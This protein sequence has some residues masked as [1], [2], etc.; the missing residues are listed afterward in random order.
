MKLSVIQEEGWRATVGDSIRSSAAVFLAGGLLIFGSY[1]KCIYGLDVSAGAVVWAAATKNRVQASVAIHA[2]SGVAVV[3]GWDDNV[4]GVW[5][6]VM[7]QFYRQRLRGEQC[8]LR[9][10]SMRVA[11]PL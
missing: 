4:Y 10:C 2:V 8:G 6:R 3:G 9:L 11:V 7:A 5:P 1:D